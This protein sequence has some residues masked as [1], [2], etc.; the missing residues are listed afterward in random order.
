MSLSKHKQNFVHVIGRIAYYIISDIYRT[1]TEAILERS[2]RKRHR[3]S[4]INNGA[5]GF[6]VGHD[7]TSGSRE[8]SPQ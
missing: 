5:S 1:F 4:L 3:I 2:Y 8:S 7:N 6:R